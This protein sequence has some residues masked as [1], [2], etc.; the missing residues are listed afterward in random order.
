[1]NNY[2]LADMQTWPR[3]E[4]FEFFSA[5]S[6]PF[7]SV[8]YRLDVTKLCEFARREGVSFYLALTYLVTSAIN[9]VEAFKYFLADGKLARLTERIPS[10]TDKKEDSE[11][12]HIVTMPAEGSILDFCRAAKEKSSRQTEFIDMSSEGDDLLFIS[13]LPWLDITALTNERNF[14]PDDAVPR[15]AWGKFVEENG[16]KVLGMSVEVNH[17]FI[18]GTHIGKFN[19]ELCRLIN[20]LN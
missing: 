1:M 13:S 2:E 12:F 5:A 14:D 11:L 8:T 20:E 18:D 7:Y 9:S 10:F 19:D 15:I 3:R 17:R 16:R 4:L 6:Q